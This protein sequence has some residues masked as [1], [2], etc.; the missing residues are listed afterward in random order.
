MLKKSFH[1]PK[2]WIGVVLGCIWLYPLLINYIPSK[3]FSTRAFEENGVTVI[4]SS[5]GPS[6]EFLWLWPR[7]L[8]LIVV[9]ILGLLQARGWQSYANRFSYLLLTYLGF[10]ILGCFNARDD[11]YT[12]TLLGPENRMDG[13]LYQIALVLVAL[14][15]YRVLKEHPTAQRYLVLG[16]IIVGII[17]AGVLVLQRLGHDPIGPLLRGSPYEIPVGTIGHP[18]MVAGLLLAIVVGG[19]GVLPYLQGAFTRVFVLIGLIIIAAGL[20]ITTNKASF[21]A[22]LVVLVIWNLI[23]R[24]RWLLS[25]SMVILLAIT[26][27]PKLIPNNIGFQRSFTDPTTGRT[28]F[29]IWELALQALA[30]LPLSPWVGSGPDAFRLALLRHIPPEDLMRE[31]RLEFGWPPDARIKELHI[32][33]NPGDPIRSKAFLVFFENYKTTNNKSA[34]IYKVYLDKAHNMMLDRMLS[35]GIFAVLITLFLYLWPVVQLFPSKEPFAQGILASVLAVFL[36]Y[37]FWFPVIQVE[38]IHMA[39]VTIAW[40]LLDKTRTHTRDIKS[41]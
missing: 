17:E 30:K 36:Y 10:V 14:L 40:A 3:D 41:T 31:Y 19:I 22:L 34:Q 1:I 25:L 5:S 2:F 4:I 35:Y 20:G 27:T 38:P 16:L 18:G 24:K 8:L 11:E 21:Y 33:Y 13:L 12:S 39:F 32:L 7:V 9:G 15:T 26:L 23:I 28:R 37:Q 29:I 6:S